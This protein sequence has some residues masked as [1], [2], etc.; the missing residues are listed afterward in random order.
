MQN[1]I[2]RPV[3]MNGGLVGMVHEHLL[4]DGTI[5]YRGINLLE[6]TFGPFATHGEAEKAV[7]DSA[8]S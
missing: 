4:G 1:F 8:Y 3:T 6:E 7:I 2:G 5:E